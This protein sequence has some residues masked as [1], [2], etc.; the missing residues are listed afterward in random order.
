MLHQFQFRLFPIHD[1]DVAPAL[2]S[3]PAPAFRSLQ[4]QVVVDIKD[5]RLALST[6][7]CKDKMLLLFLLWDMIVPAVRMTE[8]ERSSSAEHGT[9]GKD[10]NECV[11][12]CT[13]AVASGGAAGGADFVGA[14]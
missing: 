13:V 7:Q 14:A 3:G 1:C 9:L 4:L 2:A 10:T 6:V 12:Q 5:A 11:P 8:E